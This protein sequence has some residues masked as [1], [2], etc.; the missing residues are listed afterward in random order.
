MGGGQGG[1]VGGG[2]EGGLA[3]PAGVRFLRSSS[4][5]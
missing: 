1:E 2:W 4:S 3:A 5:G